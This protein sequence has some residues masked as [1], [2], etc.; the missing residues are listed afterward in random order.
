M[1][2]PRITVRAKGQIT[3]PAQIVQE[4]HLAEG[5]LLEVEYLSDKDVLVLRP[6]VAVP[7][8]KSGGGH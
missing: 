2:A 6:V 8:P 4:L 1:P 3:L 5:D 7:R